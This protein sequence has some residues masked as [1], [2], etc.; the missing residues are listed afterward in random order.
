MYS[1]SAPAGRPRAC[2]HFERADG[3]ARTVAEMP[4]AQCWYP[5]ALQAFDQRGA[6]PQR[7]ATVLLTPA[8]GVE[9][10]RAQ[11]QPYLA[12]R[13]A[14]LAVPFQS[15]EPYAYCQQAPLLYTS[16][17][18]ATWSYGGAAVQATGRPAMVMGVPAQQSAMRSH[19]LASRPMEG[20][21]VHSGPYPA[22][23]P[24]RIV[25]AEAGQLW[26]TRF[27]SE[28]GQGL[29]HGGARSVWRPC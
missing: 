7:S 21:A 11:P 4:A 20:A 3:E 16:A 28:G 18:L 23:T 5:S 13:P 15:V 6:P 24:G 22:G 19:L 26:G 10:H 2:E 17:P 27:V 29:V 25:R 1:T 12:E 9:S 8:C 14:L